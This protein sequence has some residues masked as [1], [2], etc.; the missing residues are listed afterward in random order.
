[1]HLAHNCIARCGEGWERGAAVAM[2]HGTSPSTARRKEDPPSPANRS[3]ERIASAVRSSHWVVARPAFDYLRA[4][5]RRG[6]TVMR[7]RSGSIER[8]I[9]SAFRRRFIPQVA[10][11][12]DLAQ[13]FFLFKWRD[14]SIFSLLPFFFSFQEGRQAVPSNR[15]SFFVV[16]SGQTVGSETSQCSL[17]LEDGLIQ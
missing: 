7:P 11:T 2:T 15:E 5:A 3:A 6:F 9:P 4:H 13:G 10:Q 12:R 1:M 17:F 14:G 8:Q 16:I